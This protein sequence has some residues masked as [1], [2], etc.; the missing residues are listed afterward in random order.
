MIGLS[1]QSICARFGQFDSDWTNLPDWE[2]ISK[3]IH[4]SMV[5]WTTT[6][7]GK[8]K[9][10]IPQKNILCNGSWDKSYSFS[11]EIIQLLHDIP[12][13]NLLKNKHEVIKR[14]TKTECINL[15]HGP[16]G[17]H[18]Q[19]GLENPGQG[20]SCATHPKLKYIQ[21]L[22]PAAAQHSFWRFTN[23]FLFY[24]LASF[25]HLFH[26]LCLLWILLPCQ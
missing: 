18:H 9:V 20:G 25:D 10:L 2:I 8:H 16:P 4:K 15:V 21:I 5:F 19:E 23:S 12:V 26:D 6:S 13:T 14:L 11:N 22:L 17:L 24:N 3:T 1:W 7:H